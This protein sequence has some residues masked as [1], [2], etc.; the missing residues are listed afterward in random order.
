ML[1]A[2]IKISNFND[3]LEALSGIKVISTYLKTATSNHV[4]SL[5]RHG[6]FPTMLEH[7]LQKGM[8]YLDKGLQKTYVLS[9][10]LEEINNSGKPI[11]I[12]SSALVIF[13]HQSSE[14]GI[15]SHA[16]YA[17][18]DITKNYFCVDI[19]IELRNVDEEYL[20]QWRIFEQIQLF[21]SLIPMQ[22]YHLSSSTRWEKPAENERDVKLLISRGNNGQYP[23]LGSIEYNVKGVGTEQVLKLCNDIC[24]TA[25]MGYNEDRVKF[26]PVK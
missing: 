13:N 4:P 11:V 19:Y 9:E 15:S 16:I 1:N 5:D 6:D 23:T 12:P 26:G 22:R 20:K 7:T 24:L 17:Q 25:E 8:E 2:K 21:T 10:S 14:H 18:V 3:S